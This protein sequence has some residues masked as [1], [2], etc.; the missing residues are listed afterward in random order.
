MTMN[1]DEISLSPADLAEEQR[2]TPNPPDIEK[3]AP[4]RDERLFLVLSIFIGIVSGLLVV[5]F[6]ISINWFQVL[7]LGSAPHAGQLR[8]FIVPT[9]AGVII[10][11]LVQLLFPGARGSGVNQT[12][13]ALYIYNG[14]ISFRTVIGKFITAALAIGAGFSLGPE[15]PS[16]Q[17]GAGVA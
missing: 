3:L 13:A 5:C 8:L 9:I 14:Y 16:L 2:Y 10:A 15:D 7:T 11:A 4:H 6:R 17:L 1:S 12:K